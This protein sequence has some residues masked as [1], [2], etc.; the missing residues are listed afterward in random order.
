LRLRCDVVIDASQDKSQNTLEAV[1][2]SVPKSFA[3]PFD[4]VGGCEQAKKILTQVCIT[5]HSQCTIQNNRFSF[6]QAIVWPL[7]RIDEMRALGTKPI[8][9]IILHGP[10]GCGKTSLARAVAA[11]APHVAFFSLSAPEIVIPTLICAPE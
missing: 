9:G 4:H 2:L 11:L 8:T 6:F 5:M 1:K 3:I 7:T 10:P